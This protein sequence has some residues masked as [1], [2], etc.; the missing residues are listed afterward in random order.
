[1][2]SYF[3]LPIKGAFA[4]SLAV[5][6]LALIGIGAYKGKLAQLDLLRSIG[7]VVAVGAVSGLG[8]YLLGAV[9]PHLFGY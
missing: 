4:V 6:L 2:I 5:T 7:E 3:F 1:M 9:L 8:G